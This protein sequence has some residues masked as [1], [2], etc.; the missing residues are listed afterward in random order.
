MP[1]SCGE[2]RDT[3]AK[4][5]KQAP[6]Y[7]QKSKSF[8][9]LKAPPNMEE[10]QSQYVLSSQVNMVVQSES[11]KDKKDGKEKKVVLEKKKIRYGPSRLG[12]TAG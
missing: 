10:M 4:V 2:D 6:S 3:H 8:N 9:V 1:L 5:M 11:R 7:S 12:W